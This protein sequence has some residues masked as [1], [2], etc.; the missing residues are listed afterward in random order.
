MNETPEPPPCVRCGAPWAEHPAG[1]CPRPP[2]YPQ[3]AHSSMRAPL[4]VGSLIAILLAAFVAVHVINAE[5]SK[6]SPPAACQLIGG[7]WDIWNGWQCG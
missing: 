6:D 4:T 7:H 1:Q 3:R 5:M 2:L